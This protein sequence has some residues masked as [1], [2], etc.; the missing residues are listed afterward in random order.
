[1]AM[2]DAARINLPSGKTF[3]AMAPD[4]EES[5]TVTR[6]GITRPPRVWGSSARTSSV[7]IASTTPS[8]TTSG[9]GPAGTP[10]GS[11]FFRA[12]NKGA[13]ESLNWFWRGWFVENWKLD[14]AV[15][16]VGYVDDEPSTG[17]VSRR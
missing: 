9:P 6:S 17:L 8:E 4:P 7:M 10:P 3:L 2:C 1:M 15:K 5:T 12:T 16:D 11:F 13:G 14:Q